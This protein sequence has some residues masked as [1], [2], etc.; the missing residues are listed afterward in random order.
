MLFSDIAQFRDDCKYSDCLHIN[1]DGCNVLEN[2][3]KIDESRYESYI[4]FIDEAKEYKERIKFEGKKQEYSKKI[5]HNKQ[6]AKIS[7]KKRQ[8]SRNTLKQQI[9][10]ENENE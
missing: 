4:A 9:I 3:D 1:E 7:E 5:V 10:K 2:I 8:R 6:I